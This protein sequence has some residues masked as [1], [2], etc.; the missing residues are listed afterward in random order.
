MYQQPIPVPNP[1]K[2]R[3]LGRGV[4]VRARSTDHGLPLHVLAQKLLC[5]PSVPQALNPRLEAGGSSWN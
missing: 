3:S 5:N 2:C 4:H 1:R